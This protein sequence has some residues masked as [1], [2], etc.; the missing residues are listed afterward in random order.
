MIDAIE[1]ELQRWVSGDGSWLSVL[2]GN[3]LFPSGKLLRPV[4]CLESA[5]AVGG[6]VEAILPWAAGIELLHLA[7][8]IHDD[9]LDRD[10]V[11][12]GRESLQHRYGFEDALLAGDGMLCYAVVAMMGCSER[13]VSDA[14]ILSAIR[15]TMQLAKKACQ[16]A[17]LEGTLRGDLSI[18]QTV[19]LEVIR[20]KTAGIMQAACQSGAI[21]SG[22]TDSQVAALCR[23]GEELGM[24]FQMRDDLLPYLSDADS[25][26]KS[27]T[28]D[29][30]NRNPTLPVVLA[31][32]RM[33]ESD[34]IRLRE[35]F[36]APTIS[37]STHREVR[38][39]L[40][41]AGAIAEVTQRARVH[42]QRA[43][44]SLSSLPPSGS[45]DRLTEL[46]ATAVDRAS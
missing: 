18:D 8:L 34:R 7:T 39:L 12:R 22:A 29:I 10:P 45:R 27:I 24:A 23:Y 9:I 14:R 32:K 2:C 19:C 26:G 20:G 42:A 46:A 3:A 40:V 13:G 31:Y 6:D 37:L 25:I 33:E 36:A 11:R 28:S 43:R 1:A 5:M 4:L 35:I 16:A 38:D 44:E 21:L 41:H 17:L 30:Q 15:G